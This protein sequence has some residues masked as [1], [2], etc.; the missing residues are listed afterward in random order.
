MTANFDLTRSIPEAKFTEIEKQR[1]VNA[2]MQWFFIFRRNLIYLMQNTGVVAATQ[3]NAVILGLFILAL[4]WKRYK[5]NEDEVYALI[6]DHILTD[7]ENIPLIVN[8]YF[9]NLFQDWIGYIMIFLMCIMFNSAL[10]V[11]MQIPLQVPIFKAELM[12]RMYH[13][14]TYFYGRFLS[15]YLFDVTAPL[16]LFFTAFYGLGANEASID[17]FYCVGA[18]MLSGIL[19][20]AVGYICALIFDDH[21][22]ARNFLVMILILWICNMGVL[23]NIE[24]NDFTRFAQ[25]ISPPRFASEILLRSLTKGKVFVV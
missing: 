14:V 12:S 23:V 16:I 10:T 18:A 2:F 3:L 22:D 25:Y 4:Y 11:I 7:P 5:I 21:I 8:G 24:T 6:E 13:P 19:G 9:S 17:V 15:N 1:K 20:N